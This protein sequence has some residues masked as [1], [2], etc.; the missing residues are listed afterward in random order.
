MRAKG[1]RD[2]MEVV[3]PRCGSQTATRISRM[4]QM[5][6]CSS[7]GV[8]FCIN[9]RG[10]Y[11]IEEGWAATRLG[12]RL[13]ALSK[14]LGLSGV[15]KALSA[16]GE[17]VRSTFSQRWLRLPRP[18]RLLISV[19]G[20]SCLAIVAVSLAFSTWAMRDDAP[21]EQSESLDVRA[22]VACQALL[23][24]DDA[25]LEGLTT[26]DTREEARQWMQQI[27]PQAWP[28]TP[29]LAK[30]AQVDFQ[31]LF[32]SLKTQRAAMY[33]KIRTVANRNSDGAPDL[34]GTLCW[35]LGH[36]GRWQLDGRRTL[37]EVSLARST[38]N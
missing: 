24:G 27:R 11:V 13:T 14:Q 31:T 20:G 22:E 1:A 18:W 15:L 37:A 17:H 34:E 2:T 28:R 9:E 19:G 32:K 35:T 8:S 12:R 23:L 36:D 38:D 29:D 33:Y 21:K 3:C 30:T 6:T 26:R 7:C 16:G 25:V 4:N 5:R 10:R